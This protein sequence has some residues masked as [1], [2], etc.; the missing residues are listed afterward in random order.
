MTRRDPTNVLLH[1]NTRIFLN[2]FDA[3]FLSIN[4]ENYLYR[5]SITRDIGIVKLT[6][7][8]GYYFDSSGKYL[9]DTQCPLMKVRRTCENI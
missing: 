3:E 1:P 5:F 9:S 8:Q 4:Y 7:S 2:A 6:V